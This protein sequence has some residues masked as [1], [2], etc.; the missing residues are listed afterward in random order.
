MD[1]T[2]HPPQLPDPPR[3][4]PVDLQGRLAAL[5]NPTYKH[6]E[7]QHP[8]HLGRE[9][10]GE[11]REHAWAQEHWLIRARRGCGREPG[12]PEGGGDRV[13]QDWRGV[14]GDGACHAIKTS[15]TGAIFS[16]AN[17]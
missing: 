11:V 12:V 17:H 13:R 10:G 16:R 6:V 15:Q 1:N 9:L 4:A 8:R 3:G 2:Q 5:P 14:L 7:P